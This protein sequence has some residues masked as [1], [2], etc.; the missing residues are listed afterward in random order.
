MKLFVS[1]IRNEVDL[2]TGT[3]LNVL[4]LSDGEKEADVPVADDV[5]E[6]VMTTFREGMDHLDNPAN[7]SQPKTDLP[8]PQ[9]P[10]GFG[11]GP[12]I[13]LGEG[14]SPEDDG[15]EEWLVSEDHQEEK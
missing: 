14:N 12:E 9:E 5:F 8:S 6:H 10:D 15:D 1:R 4:V 2:L 3:Y 11:L 13:D 7:D